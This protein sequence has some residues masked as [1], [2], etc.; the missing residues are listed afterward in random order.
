MIHI[1]DYG[2]GNLGSIVNMCKRLGIAATISSECADVERA[3]RL[4]LPGVGHFD[5]GMT[6]LRALDL[7][8]PLG[9]RVLSGGAPILGICLGAQLMTRGSHEG[10]EPGLG[11]VA[12]ET[13]RFDTA[14]FETPVKVPHMGWTDVTVE[15]ENPLIEAGARFYFVHSFHFACDAREDVVATAVHGYRFVAAFARKNLFGVQF[16]PEKSHRFG[17]SLLERFAR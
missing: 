3:E 12:A 17:M 5:Q 4:I 2:L 11:W 16:H 6:K 10:S 7:I 15:Q 13:V 14:R 8:G 1:V 9:E